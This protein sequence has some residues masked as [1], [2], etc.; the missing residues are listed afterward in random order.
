MKHIL[1]ECLVVPG[2]A[3][4]AG[5]TTANKADTVPALIAL[6]RGSISSLVPALL[7]ACLPHR[8]K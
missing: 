8:N 4:G 7:L 5:N 6:F 1:S 2:P 3:Q